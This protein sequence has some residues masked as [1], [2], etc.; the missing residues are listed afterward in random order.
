MASATI[1][2][3]KARKR[4]VRKDVKAALRPTATTNP[5]S[6]ATGTFGRGSVGPAAK[7]VTNPRPKTQKPGA[8]GKYKWPG[9]SVARHT[10]PFGKQ[11]RDDTP[12]GG[13]G[14]GGGG[15]GA[16]KRRDAWRKQPLVPGSSITNWEAK[17]ARRA[18][19][20]LMFGDKLRAEKQAVNQEEQRTRDMGGYYD[21][22]LKQLANHTAQATQF[23]AAAQAQ[24]QTAL[25]GVTGLSQTNQTQMQGAANTDAAAR[26]A[27]AADTSEMANQA[28]AVRQGLVAGFIA[29]QG[30]VNSSRENYANMLE[31]AGS[32]QKLQA[33]AQGAGQQRKAR[34]DVIDTKGDRA[35]YLQKLKAEQKESEGKNVLA[36][37][38]LGLE[39]QQQGFE[40]RL[41]TAKFGEDVKSRKAQDRIDQ[42]RID[43]SIRNA[44]AQ[45]AA[46]DG[47]VA[48]TGAFQGKTMGQIK[49]M[50]PQQQAQAIR[51]YDKA[52]AA[53]GKGKG[54]DKAGSPKLYPGT[55]GKAYGQLPLLKGLIEK[56]SRGVPFV[57][58]HKK[59]PKLTDRQAQ[60]KKIFERVGTKLMSPVLLSAAQDAVHDGHLSPATV[61]R[62]RQYGLDPREVARVLGIS[63]GSSP[64]GLV[65][66]N[67]AAS[68][69]KGLPPEVRHQ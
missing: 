29:Q 67:T 8:G 47:K 42:S 27:T 4:N 58:G 30:G 54:T 38:A 62:L 63:A 35:A 37:Q 3:P 66:K 7:T 45:I 36:A 15:G 31:V 22:Y 1:T 65:E 68:T 52:H 13:G 28:A 9:E 12:A 10:R 19:A 33:M 60:N 44:D 25:Q 57:E 34:Q 56:A 17:K 48:L 24:N 49:A 18:D 5:P 14:G 23:G 21:D 39:T 11:Y 50:S 53:K 46:S 55:A 40:N 20:R 59:Q 69:G 32:G 2:A 41:A 51:A 43:A 16:R 64:G 61:K 26:G 6:A